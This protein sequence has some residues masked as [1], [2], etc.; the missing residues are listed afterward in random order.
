MERLWVAELLISERTAAK[1]VAVHQITPQE[2]RDAVVCVGGLEW[3]WDEDQERG[4]RALVRVDIR[5]RPA[6]AVLYDAEH[7]LGDTWH[8]GSTYF[9]D[10]G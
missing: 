3:V 6:I 1:I 5:G 2:A 9:V 8:L 4:G 7:P 10:R